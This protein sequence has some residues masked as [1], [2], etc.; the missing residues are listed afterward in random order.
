[1]QMLPMSVKQC[2]QSLDCISGIID[3]KNLN[4]AAIEILSKDEAHNEQM[5]RDIKELGDVPVILGG[6][7]DVE[8]CV[9]RMKY[10]DA[11]LVGTCFEDGKWGGP[12]NVN[13][14][15]AY[16]DNMKSVYDC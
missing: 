1:M 9:R 10:A 6:G 4:A 2:L 12:I 3:L 14:V 16:M 8:N 13:T 15:K 5:V 7:T 11:A